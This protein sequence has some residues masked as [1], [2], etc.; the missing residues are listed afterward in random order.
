MSVLTS[1]V[2]LLGHALPATRASRLLILIYHRVPERPDAMFQLEI[3]AERFD[4]QMALLRRH[5]HPIGLGEGVRRL[6][7]GTLPP[8]AVAV[9]FDDGYADN[10]TVALPI[11]QHYAV[12]ATFFVATAFLDGGRMWNDTVIETVRR[13]DGHELDLRG[14]GL[15]IEA[16]GDAAARGTLAQKILRTVKHLHPAERLAKVEALREQIGAPLPDDLMMT[17]AQVCRLAEAGMEV[18]AHTVNH[19]IL[20]TLPDEQATAEIRDNRARLEQITGRAVTAFAYPNGRPGDDY[21]R[22]DRD[23]VESLGFD[24]AV[25]TT[26]GAATAQSDLF[27]L[28]RFGAWDRT[29]ERWLARLLLAFRRAR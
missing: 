9:T 5:C 11:L 29:P 13:A 20:R 19:P 14:L 1:T 28:P 12:P 10:A 25:S 18:G 26:L 8:R 6:R 4:W 21:T 23:L 7:E 17:T 3:C 22:R 2:S 24:H 27:Q 15:E 16:L